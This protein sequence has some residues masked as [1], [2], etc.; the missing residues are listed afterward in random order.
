[1]VVGC[2]AD[3]VSVEIHMTDSGFNGVFYVKGHSKDTR[4]R[5]VVTLP[6]D[7]PPRTETFKVHFGECG[8]VHVNVTII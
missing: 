1:M 6:A 5:R 7:S 2:L 8:L 4:C 3:G